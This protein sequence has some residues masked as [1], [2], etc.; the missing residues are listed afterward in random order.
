MHKGG[1]SY[2]IR[3]MKR[4]AFLRDFGGN[5]LNVTH[6]WWVKAKNFSEYPWVGQNVDIEWERLQ[7][8]YIDLYFDQNSVF[9]KLLQANLAYVV[10]L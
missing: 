10:H 7:K 6:L 8:I 3:S 1:S 2:R 4:D 5:I 9:P